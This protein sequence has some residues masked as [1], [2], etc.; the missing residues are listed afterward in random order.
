MPLKSLGCR[1]N[2]GLPCAPIFVVPSSKILAPAAAGARILDDGTTKIGA[3][4]N[5]VLFLHP[6]D[7]NGTLIELE[8][9]AKTSELSQKD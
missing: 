4:G 6:K 5:P 2:T 7:F 9:V 8:Q 1:N 3:H